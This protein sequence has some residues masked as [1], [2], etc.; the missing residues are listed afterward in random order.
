MFPCGLVVNPKDSLLGASPDRVVY[1]LTSDPPY[2]GFEIKCIESGKAIT[3]LRTYQA[4]REPQCGKKKSFCLL[5]NGEILELALNHHYHQQVQ[6][7]CCV[8]GLRWNDFV[9]M[10]DL[11]FGDQGVHVQR[12]H[13]DEKWHETSL[14]K[15][16]FS[17]SRLLWT[18][19]PHL[20]T[21]KMF[22]PELS[23][24]IVLQYIFYS[25]LGQWLK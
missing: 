1:D 12:I 17:P 18:R 20:T 9:L 13:F 2:G 22:F 19:H 23:E 24:V 3:P 25:C 15:P 14:P 21:F 5:K 11:T 8:L 16:F 4:K 7:Q 6:G 10:T